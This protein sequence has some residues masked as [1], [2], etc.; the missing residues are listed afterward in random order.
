MSNSRRGS[1]W[2]NLVPSKDAVTENLAVTRVRATPYDLVILWSQEGL[3]DED[4]D[5]LHDLAHDLADTT[6]CVAVAV[7]P[8]R[9]LHSA[10]SHD[11]VSLIRLRDHLDE[12]IVTLSTEQQVG[13]A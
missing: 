8:D 9:V 3:P 10:S 2:T 6:D 13:D 4:M 7:V 5:A 1:P 11:L 12:A